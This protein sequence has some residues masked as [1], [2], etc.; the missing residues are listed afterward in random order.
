MIWASSLEI[1]R[2]GVVQ[3]S[4]WVH[5]LILSSVRTQTSLGQ[6]FLIKVS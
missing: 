2:E 5:D 4:I 6:S 3:T 1:L